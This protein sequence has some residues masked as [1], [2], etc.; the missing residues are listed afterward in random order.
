MPD[1]ILSQEEIDAL[2]RGETAF[3]E[4]RKPDA[5]LTDME[6]DVL[7]EIG[8]ISMGTAATT[9]S[10]LLRRKVSIT[11]PQVKLTSKEQLQTDYPLPY[12]LIEV[13]YTEGLSG[14]NILVVKKEDASVIADLMM[15]GDGSRR[16][17][18]LGEIELS[19]VSEAM[20]QMMGSATT[21][22][23]SMFDR[24]I[25]IAPPRLT[26]VDFGKDSIE[27]TLGQEYRDIVQILFRMEIEGLVDSEIMQIM[28]LEAAKKMVAVLMGG[29]AES[30]DVAVIT[31]APPQE[32]VV[33][34]GVSVAG[35]LREVQMSPPPPPISMPSMSGAEQHSRGFALEAEG[36]GETRKAKVAVQPVQFG[37]LI[38]ETHYVETQNISLIL[39]VPL[40]VS[41]E[42]GRTRKTIKE[43]LD[44]GPGSIIQL[45]K[46]AGEP[47]DILVN[48]KLIAKGEVVVI[49][50]NYGVRVTA[51]ISPMDRVSKLQ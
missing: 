38:P 31:P 50:E 26:V 15:G 49:D 23:S 29:V 14:S 41:V 30:G 20:N 43:I 34:P 21:S 4:Q 17:Q 46:L 11:T 8:N 42:L 44:L 28:P 35:D 27:T 19:A 51:I 40:N 45:E 39:D 10:T 12:L 1:G 47:V 25:E 7:G 36:M 32:P 13:E 3:Q 5:M 33:Q 16:E 2:L 18:E 24:R 48:G 22:L 6:K 9:L 37:P